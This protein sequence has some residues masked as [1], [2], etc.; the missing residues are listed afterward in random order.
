MGPTGEEITAIPG[1]AVIFTEIQFT[2][3]PLISAR[4][5]NATEIRSIASFTVRD[6]R[7]L[8]QIYQQNPA[9]PDPVQN[10]GAYLG[11]ITVGSAGEVN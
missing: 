10:C 11:T 9:E 7:D 8:T 1:D 2:Y 4:F 6:Q 3:Q 5:V